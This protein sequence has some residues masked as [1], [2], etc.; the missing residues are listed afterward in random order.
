MTSNCPNERAFTDLS[1][2][3]KYKPASGV[4]AKQLEA[5]IIHTWQTFNMYACIA[6][7]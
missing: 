3:K 6:D 4:K 1:L 2:W 5:K 7:F